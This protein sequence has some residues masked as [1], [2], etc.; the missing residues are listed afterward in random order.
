MNIFNMMVL[1]LFVLTSCAE[2]P[3]KQKYF[4]EGRNYPHIIKKGNIDL[5]K[6]KSPSSDLKWLIYVSSTLPDDDSIELLTHYSLADNYLS[7]SVDTRADQLSD[8][9]LGLQSIQKLVEVAS[10]SIKTQSANA[11]IQ[12]QLLL[13]GGVNCVLISVLDKESFS[14][15]YSGSSFN[16]SNNIERRQLICPVFIRDTLVLAKVTLAIKYRSSNKLADDARVKILSDFMHVV[17]SLEFIEPVTQ[18][19]PDGFL[20]DEQLK[21]MHDPKWKF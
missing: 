13:A 20:L 9:Y 14:Y 2:M 19:V 3:P 1:L 10:K 11:D 5:F 15:D 17:N 4:E 16:V 21:R 8:F 7:G 6:L 12:A 18:K